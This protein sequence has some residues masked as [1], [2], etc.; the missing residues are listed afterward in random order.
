MVSRSC[1]EDLQFRIATPFVPEM[2]CFSC[3]SAPLIL[4]NFLEKK[5][6][7]GAEEK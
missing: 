4:E 5:N 2:E 6:R 3:S 1:T 7:R